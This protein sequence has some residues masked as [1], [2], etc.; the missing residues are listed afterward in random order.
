[1]IA[2]SNEHKERQ[3]ERA[4]ERY[5]FTNDQAARLEAIALADELG[6]RFAAAVLRDP[7]ILDVNFMEPIPMM[8]EPPKWE[9]FSPSWFGFGVFR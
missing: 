6:K 8:T 4:L 3:F 2:V 7:S 5:V 1:M 9:P